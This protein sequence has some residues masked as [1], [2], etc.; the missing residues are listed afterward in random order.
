MMTMKLAKPLLFGAALALT[1]QAQAECPQTMPAMQPAIPDG[2]SANEATMLSAQAA[3]NAYI[4]E[5]D[6]F[7][8][9]R[10]LHPMLHNRLRSK[11]VQVATEYNRELDTYLDRSEL[12]AGR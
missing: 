11:L 2:A 3:V 8:A 9:C 12:V 4:A 10:D 7:L 6:A 5:G 1:A